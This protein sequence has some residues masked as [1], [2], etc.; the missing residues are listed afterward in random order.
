[1]VSLGSNRG[2]LNGPA[3]YSL[4]R[5]DV[6][7]GHLWQITE[8]G[9]TWDQQNEHYQHYL[10]YGSPIALSPNAPSLHQMGNAIDTNERITWLLNENGWYQT[11][12]RWV[13][14]VWTLVEPWHYEYFAERDDHYGETAGGGAVEFPEEEDDMPSMNE[15]LNTPAYDNGPTISEMF[16]KINSVY[17]AIFIG[18]ADMP[19]NGRSIGQSLDGVVTW[20]DT[21]G[22]TI[23]TNV[24]GLA[25]GDGTEP[26]PEPEPEPPKA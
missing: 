17:D 9:R 19:D 14:G 3:A 24:A 16:V 25:D 7:I 21:T 13:N 26:E 12:F 1:M 18:G 8:A 6:R 10:Q 15:F 23:A 4:F 2:W 22:N 20:L 11:V 5:L